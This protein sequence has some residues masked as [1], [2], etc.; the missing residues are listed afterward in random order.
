M[1]IDSDN[2]SSAQSMDDIFLSHLDSV[3]YHEDYEKLKRIENEVA[4]SVEQ[5][6]N[7]GQNI[8]LP[9]HINDPARAV[10]P[11]LAAHIEHHSLLNSIPTTTTAAITSSSQTTKSGK[12]YT[13]RPSTSGIKTQNQMQS[14]AGGSSSGGVRKERSLHYC[15]ICSKGFKDK[16]SVNV[17]IRTH[18]GEKPFNCSLCG[19]SFRQ[20]AHLAKHYHTHL[21]QSK[22]SSN[23]SSSSASSSTSSSKTLNKS[24]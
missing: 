16:Y 24:R 5:Y 18:T 12:K 1:L 8:Y 7:S 10:Q 3:P 4:E 9:V 22:N 2:P 19:K 20:K 15:N 21:T 13:K 11:A 6:C 14:A 23:G 17:H